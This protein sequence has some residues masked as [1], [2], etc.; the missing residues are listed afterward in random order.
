MGVAAS[1]VWYDTQDG[2]HR[3]GGAPHP[4]LPHP[5]MHAGRGVKGG[6]PGAEMTFEG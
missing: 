4:A 3:S 5:R 1:R 2:R 6:Y